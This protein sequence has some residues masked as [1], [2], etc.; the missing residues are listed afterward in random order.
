MATKAWTYDGLV[1]V[2]GAN[3]RE[4]YFAE[5]EK[6]GVPLDPT[7]GELE[8]Y[9]LPVA[10]F[11]QEDWDGSYMYPCAIEDKPGSGYVKVSFIEKPLIIQK[12]DCA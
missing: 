12:A 7:V 5:A 3:S 9:R 2:R 4:E 1:I 8:T 11:R 6:L 10:H